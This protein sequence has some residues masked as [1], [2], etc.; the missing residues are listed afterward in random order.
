MVQDLAFLASN[1]AQKHV[2]KQA[3]AFK[4]TSHT[5]SMQQCMY[6]LFPRP[7][8]SLSTDQV[9]DSRESN[10]SPARDNK[11]LNFWNPQ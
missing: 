3:A 8:G 1:K 5:A 10:P 2:F 11:P 7:F 4:A 6:V 9:K